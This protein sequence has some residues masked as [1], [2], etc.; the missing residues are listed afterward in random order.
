MICFFGDTTQRIFA[1]QT[2]NAIDPETISKLSLGFVTGYETQKIPELMC[3]LASKTD[4]T[5]FE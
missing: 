5:T 3:V 4:Q 1:L 2:Q